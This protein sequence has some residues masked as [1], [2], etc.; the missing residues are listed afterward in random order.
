[1]QEKLKY[2]FLNLA[3]YFS[4]D[5]IFLFR[6][7]RVR[8]VLLIEFIW[9]IF[10]IYQ[11][12]ADS[13][14]TTYIYL[15]LIF[16]ISIP[17]V[18]W[19]SYISNFFGSEKQGFMFYMFSPSKFRYVLF[20]KN[21][22]YFVVKLPFLVVTTIV[23]TLYFPFSFLPS[24]FICQIS[25]LLLVLTY[26]TYNSVVFATSV[27]ANDKL[28]F[29]PAKKFSLIGFLGLF[30]SFT[31]PPLLGLAVKF[32][33]GTP[34]ILLFLVIFTSLLI[35]LYLKIINHLC[36]VFE[37]QKEQIFKELMNYD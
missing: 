3:P 9:Y 1:M 29:T 20:A 23:F 37:N 31:M 18:F 14:Y 21:F 28:L 17:I 36:V 24:L 34:I 13:N 16:F 11:I 32:F 33:V 5:L 25:I 15:M 8:V 27:N 26:S 6:S 22:S 4:K 12:N 19:D 30:L 7:R 2:F 35:I 10:C